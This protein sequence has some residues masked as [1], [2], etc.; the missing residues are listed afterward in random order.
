[1]IEDKGFKWAFVGLTKLSEP[2]S[3]KLLENEYFQKAFFLELFITHYFVKSVTI[4]IKHII[5]IY[6]IICIIQL[7]HTLIV[8]ILFLLLLLF[9]C[10]SICLF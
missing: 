2:K 3:R 10:Y 9:Y 4:N 7:L 5:I 8:I 6:I 1:M